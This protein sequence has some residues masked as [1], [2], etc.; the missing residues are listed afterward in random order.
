[1]SRHVVSAVLLWIALTAAGEAL[2]LVDLFPV[3]ASEFAKESDSIFLLLMYIGIPVWA[4]AVSV[5]VYAVLQFRQQKPGETGA[6]FR[7]TGLAPRLWVLVTGALATA[8][9]IHPGLTGL[10]KLQDDSTGYGW[11]DRDAELVIEA[12]GFRW[13]WTFKYPEEGISLIG[14]AQPLTVPVHTKIRFNINSTDVVHSFWVPAWR[15]KIDAIPGRTTF[16][17]IE[18]TRLGEFHETDKNSAFR[19]QCAELCGEDHQ[20]MNFPI[21]VVERDEYEAWVREMQASQSRTQ[22]G[23]K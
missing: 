20:L 5:V 8:V 1:V 16:V 19:V 21:R 22:A 17:T 2:V 9:M 23:A 11:G 7:G 18:T 3:E 14:H 10:A 13:A 4:F 12:T 6:T 15:M